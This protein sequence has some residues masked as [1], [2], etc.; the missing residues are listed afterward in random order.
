MSKN[1]QSGF[2]ATGLVPYNPSQVLSKLSIRLRTFSPDNS[3]LQRISP[4]T[5]KT[6]Y[7]LSEL[8]KQVQ[9]VRELL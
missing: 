3:A 4:W 7:T 8:Q 2:L 5:S 1:I 9:G 6:P